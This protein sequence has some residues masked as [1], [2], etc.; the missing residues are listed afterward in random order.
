MSL[1]YNA[2][3]SSK[4]TTCF[5]ETNIV[6]TI[7]LLTIVSKCGNVKSKTIGDFTM[8]FQKLEEA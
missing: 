5:I 8:P 6:M 1:N 3:Q 2:E 7:P 4:I